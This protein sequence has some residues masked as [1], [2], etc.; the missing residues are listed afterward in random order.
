MNEQEFNLYQLQQM[1][2]APLEAATLIIQAERTFWKN[3]FKRSV[4]GT[5]F[6]RALKSLEDDNE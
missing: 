6:D 5:D 2:R 4:D 1:E 3:M